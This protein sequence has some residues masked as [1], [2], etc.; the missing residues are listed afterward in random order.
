[1]QAVRVHALMSLKG[2]TGLAGPR[3]YAGPDGH[4]ASDSHW[5]PGQPLTPL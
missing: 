1:M 3:S 5:K 2:S 4:D